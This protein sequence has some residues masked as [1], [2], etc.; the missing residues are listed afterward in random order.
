MTQYQGISYVL[1]PKK[2][3]TLIIKP[4][5]ATIDGQVMHTTPI[6]IIV[7]N[8]ASGQGNASPPG[9]NPLP[10]PSWPRAQPPVDMDE[11]V[12]PGENV[13]DK[14]RKEFFH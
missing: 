2:T 6:Q 4:A 8:Q 10:D 1:Q 13:D 9:F 14:I 11:V 5:S 12:K 7:H 3:G